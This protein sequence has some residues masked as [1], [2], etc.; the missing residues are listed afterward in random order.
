MITNPPVREAGGSQ[1]A[2]GGH[3]AGGEHPPP[4]RVEFRGWLLRM[5]SLHQV[6]GR[7]SVTLRT[8]H[9]VVSNR[10]VMGGGKVLGANRKDSCLKGPKVSMKLSPV[11]LPCKCAGQ[12]LTPTFALSRAGLFQN[13]AASSHPPPAQ[14]DLRGALQG[15]V[16]GAHALCWEPPGT[17]PRGQLPGRQRRTPHVREAGSQLGG[18]WGHLL[19]IWL[20]RP[21]FAWRVHQS[22][23]LCTLDKKCHPTVTHGNLKGKQYLKNLVEIFSLHIGTQPEVPADGDRGPCLWF[24]LKTVCPSAAQDNVRQTGGCETP[25][26]SA[27]GPH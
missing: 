21:G 13:S 16:Y 18:V 19:G 11:A 14:E 2:A 12:Q 10:P 5:L 20:P 6:H 24:G 7:Q 17:Q 27:D 1:R 8:L 3:H 25:R 23:S 4:P 22:F 9:S 15:Q 26:C